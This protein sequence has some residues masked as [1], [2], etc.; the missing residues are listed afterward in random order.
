M[1]PLIAFEGSRGLI[2]G[3]CVLLSPYLALTAKHVIEEIERHFGKDRLSSL[4]IYIIHFNSQ[5]IWYVSY[6]SS[7]IGTDISALVLLPR[8]EQ[9]KLCNFSNLLMTVD[10][11][12]VD[13]AVTAIGYHKS[14]INVDRN[15]SEI[16]NLSLNLN[17]IVSTGLVHEIHQSI[18]DVS[19]INFPSFSIKAHFKS[20][21]SGG[22]VFNDKKELAGLICSGFD[23]ELEN[24]E[25]HATAVSLWPSLIIKV[26]FTSQNYFPRGIELNKEYSL[27][28]LATLGCLNIYGH[29]RIEFF[30]HENGS[31]GVRRRHE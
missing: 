5:Y 15:D 7:W 30:K 18:R 27:K 20:G 4:D 22:A 6:I 31:D 17:P 8:N 10:P 3:S 11:P 19:L 21:M 26:K 28:E 23:V 2:A 29:E 24:D 12:L 1:S 9:V 16:T 13:S 14:Q 25:G